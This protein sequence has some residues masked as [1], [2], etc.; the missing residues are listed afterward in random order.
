MKG[1]TVWVSP[2]VSGHWLCDDEATVIEDLGTGYLVLQDSERVSSWGLGHFV[3][4]LELTALLTVEPY[5]PLP[6]MEAHRDRRLWEF[7]VRS[8]E[9]LGNGPCAT[10]TATRLTLVHP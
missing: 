4:D 2:S 1:E 10:G 9:R 5:V 3:C 8:L 7:N 6:E